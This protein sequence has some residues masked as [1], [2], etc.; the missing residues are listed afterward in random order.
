M[1]L[2]LYNT[3]SRKV[4]L[5][6]TLEEGVVKMYSC[7]P[8]VYSYPHIGNMRA[9]VFSDLLK[10]VLMSEGYKVINAI[11]I[12]DV[13]HLT[14]DS[15]DGEDKLEKE[16]KKQKKTAYEIADYF[17]DVFMRYL[18]ELNVIEAT[19]YPK[20]TD[21]IEEQINMVKGLEDK[22]FIYLTSDGVYFDTSKFPN[23]SEL[24]NLDVEGLKE[25]LRVKKNTEKRNKTDFALWKFSVTEEKREMEW[26]SPWGVGFPGWH[27]EC[28][29]MILKHLGTQID[30]HTGGIDH[31]PI[32]HTNEIAQTES[33]TGKKFSNFWMH[34]NF[35][36]IEKKEDADINEIDELKMSKSKGNV[37]TLDHIKEKG[38]SAMAL[39]YYYLSSHYRSELKYNDDILIS[40]NTAFNRLKEKVRLLKESNVIEDVIKTELIEDLRV[41]LMND[42]NT[43]KL[44]SRFQDI[45]NDNYI[46]DIDKLGA[47][48]YIEEVTGLN[49]D[50][51]KETFP[52]E[53]EKLANER[54]NAR[55]NKEWGKSDVLREQIKEQGYLIKDE[56]NGYNLTKII[57]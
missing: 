52:E 2:K 39:K 56:K 28:S 31:I 57:I 34:I 11:N 7:G 55:K 50:I 42:L 40:A 43:P 9:Y 45:L 23:Y 54:M 27:M 4:E 35:L 24:A 26:D 48:L 38:I 32:H 17:T 51:E 19:V 5:F 22:G 29:A 14:S 44:F 21:H 3:L 41:T 53:V 25:G 20:A 30:I 47:V 33:F 8:T 12:T 15:D 37:I 18:K 49:F 13:G 16:A 6:R 36:Q 10:R 1:K 46:K